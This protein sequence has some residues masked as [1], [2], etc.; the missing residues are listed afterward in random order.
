MGGIKLKASLNMRGYIDLYLQYVEVERFGYSI[1]YTSMLNYICPITKYSIAEIY[2]Y[3]YISLLNT[4]SISKICTKLIEYTLCL[5]HIKPC[6]IAM[7]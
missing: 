5:I 7:R 6:K 3:I 4:L 2:I 1:E